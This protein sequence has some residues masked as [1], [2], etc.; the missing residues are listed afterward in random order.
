MELPADRVPHDPE[1][2]RAVR[3][4]RTTADVDALYLWLCQLR[5]APYSYDWIDNFGRR[6]P[7]VPM[8]DLRVVRPGDTFMTIF[9]LVKAE[10]GRSVTLRMRQNGR[11]ARIFGDV[12][13]SYSIEDVPDGR[14]LVASIWFAPIGRFLSRARRDLLVWGDAAMM[15]KQLQTLCR[16]AEESSAPSE[17]TWS[18]IQ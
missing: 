5:R 8:P 10:P 13:V 1:A 3:S 16:L 17:P 12:I 18:T 11:W 6:S 2:R 9:E 4:R 7:R 15:R 14:F